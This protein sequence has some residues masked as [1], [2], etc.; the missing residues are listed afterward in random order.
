MKRKLS[1][2]GRASLSRNAKMQLATDPK[3]KKRKRMAA[4]AIKLDKQGRLWRRNKKGKR[5]R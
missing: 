5:V 1:A 4:I 3:S 2:T